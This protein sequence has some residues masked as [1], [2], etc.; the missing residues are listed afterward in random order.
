MTVHSRQGSDPDA[1]QVVRITVL[2]SAAPARRARMTR[3]RLR[4]ASGVGLVAAMV[5]AVVVALVASADLGGNHQRAGAER[6]GAR[7]AG[8]A[9]VAAAYGNPL[10]CLIVSIAPHDPRFARADFNRSVSCGQYRGYST[11]IFRRTGG[12]WVAVIEAIS[13]AC[14]VRSL[15]PPVEEELGVCLVSPRA[16]GPSR[17]P[18]SR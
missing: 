10:R 14:P 7:A 5:A 3:R 2:G 15:P 16:S 13:Y 8:P 1:P 18:P 9:G 12:M 6:A 4:I 17:S 11:A